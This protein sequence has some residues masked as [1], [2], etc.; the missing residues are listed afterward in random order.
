MSHMLYKLDEL[1]LETE[2][3]DSDA[4]ADDDELDEIVEEDSEDWLDEVATEL[5]S[6]LALEDEETELELE[7]EEATSDEEDEASLDDAEEIELELLET[8]SEELLEKMLSEEAEETELACSAVVSSEDW[9]ELDELDELCTVSPPL[10]TTDDETDE[11]ELAIENAFDDAEKVETLPFSCARA[12]LTICIIVSLLTVSLTT[13]ICWTTFS[14]SS[15]I[16]FSSRQR[17][18]EQTRWHL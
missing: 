18:V 17:T 1:S 8:I 10:E 15:S 5:D 3:E 14:L 7:A 2:L 12:S 4:V 6:E 11:D 13:V 16:F 9:D